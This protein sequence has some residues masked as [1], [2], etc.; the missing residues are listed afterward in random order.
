MLF[1]KRKEKETEKKWKTSELL[2]TL[3]SATL[4][5]DALYTLW[6]RFASE[7]G[8]HY[9]AVHVCNWKA[10][11]PYI[12]LSQ[13]E[14]IREDFESVR[15]A[16]EDI[17]GGQAQRQIYDRGTDISDVIRLEREPTHPELAQIIE[18]YQERFGE[19]QI[20]KLYLHSVPLV[21]W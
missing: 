18:R 16:V 9:T 11:G 14:R 2:R 21:H 13:Q 4:P 1:F 7:T 8:R 5:D 3:R 19:I 15:D 20:P 17:T 12:L 6:T 10:T